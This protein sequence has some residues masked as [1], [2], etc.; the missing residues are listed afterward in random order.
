MNEEN[1]N[2]CTDCEDETNCL[3][4]SGHKKCEAW[5]TWFHKQW[6]KIRNFFGVECVDSTQEEGDLN[7]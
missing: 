1:K 5:L 6:Q 3:K 7:E 4:H 2:P